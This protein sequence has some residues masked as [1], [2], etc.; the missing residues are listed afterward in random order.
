MS[1]ATSDGRPLHSHSW[2]SPKIFP[3]RKSHVEPTLMN[4][5]DDSSPSINPRLLPIVALVSAALLLT[6]A[7][8]YTLKRGAV[9][10][11]M[12]WATFLFVTGACV[13][14]AGTLKWVSRVEKHPYLRSE[15]KIQNKDAMVIGAFFTLVLLLAYCITGAAAA[16]QF[17]TRGAA[18]ILLALTWALAS[19][20]VGGAFGFLL[21][22]P[23][24]LTDDKTDRAA[25]SGLL[26]TGLDDMVDWLVKGL[27]TVLLVQAGPILVHLGNISHHMAQGLVGS[28]AAEPDVNA[29]AAFAQPV[30]VAFTL[31]GA[32]STCLVTRTY[33]TG[34][35]GRAD[36]TTTG[37]FSR[38][39]LDLGEVLLLS[40][41]Q[42]FLTTRSL[43]PGAEV[44][45]VAERLSGLSLADLHSVQE[46][47]M[48]AKAKSMLGDYKEALK[49]YE[50][51]V[52]E[53]DC[54]P[55]LL[56]D[57]SVALHAA[58]K[59]DEALPRLELAYE[60]IARAT[61]AETRRNIYKSLTFLLLYEPGNFDRVIELVEEFEH[62]RE[63]N[64]AP[65]SGGLVVNQAC[66]W[67]QKFLWLAKEK[68][69]VEEPPNQALKI[70][71]SGNPANWPSE[72]QDL[73]NAYDQAL[74]AV[75]RA[76][77]LDP[78]WK[79]QLQ[80]LL[81]RFDPA[82]SQHPDMNDLE[83]FERFD[84]IRAA[85]DLPP[86]SESAQ[87]ASADAAA[88]ETPAKPIVNPATNIAVESKESGPEAPKEGG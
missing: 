69:V 6:A 80:L 29:A 22:H 64:P 41:A 37:A 58:D 61:D 53:C 57:Y 49:G 13:V 34:A 32:L 78:S 76:V 40:N 47:A 14:I 31:L 73:K 71:I 2:R 70:T 39:G 56:L 9:E 85:L 51:A 4:T 33:L 5:N 75:K 10:A 12:I 16:M 74:A 88:K 30:I 63:K 18:A 81:R 86:Y 8:G 23:R 21:G 82:K 20:T 7:I 77:F 59:K 87:G 60:H 36:R 84:E 79:K 46:F 17:P 19:A 28:G 26:R 44:R 66:A 55:V 62:H 43:Q 50:K 52:A 25:M 3:T 35:L 54:D 68:N 42:R 72:H 38:V 83:V 27:T 24:R 67:G 48:W 15:E 45:Q 11:A 1:R 65:P